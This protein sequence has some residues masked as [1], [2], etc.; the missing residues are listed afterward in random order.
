[1]KT[2]DIIKQLLPGLIV[3]FF[4]GCILIYTVGVDKENLIPNIF[5]A[6][7]SCAVPTLLNGIIVLKG[8]SKVLD[9]KLSIGKAFMFN[10]PYI[11]I[12]GIIGFL[13]VRV[14]IMMILGLDP[15]T[16]SRVANTLLYAIFGAIIS[17]ILAYFTLK[18][19]EKK[20]KY[21]RR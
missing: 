15:C 9:R 2:K 13:F 17:T 12:G 19:Y 6:I 10:L 21:T 5:G 14:Y 8:T 4:L 7:M 16:F 3:G 18:R 11:I 20:V 1:M